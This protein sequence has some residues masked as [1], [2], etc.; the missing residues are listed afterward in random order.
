MPTRARSHILEEQSIRRF[1]DALPPAWVYRCKAPDYGIDGEVEIFNTNG[2]TT[3]LSFNV[4][5]RATDDVARAD[6]VRLEVDE[7]NYYG[8]LDVPT[9][10]VRYSSPDGSLFWQWASHIASQVELA[11]GQQTVTYRFDEGERWTE[12]TAAAIRRTLEVRRRL[13]DYPPSMGVPLRVDLSA[14]PAAERYPIDRTIAQAI[15]DSRGALVRAGSTP[16]DVEAF[17][18]LGPTILSVG[19]DT[20]TGVTFDLQIPTPNDYLSSILYALVRIFRRQ[21]LLRQAEALASL[22]AERGLAHHNQDLAFDAC[23]ALARDLPALV[24]IAIVNGLHDQGPM[25]ALVALTIVK[26]PQD[27]ESRRAAMDAFF[28]ASMA[29]ARE[30]EPASEA[31]AHYSIGNFYRHQHDL[32]RAAHHYNRARHLRPAYLQTGYFLSELAGVLFLAGHYA[33]AQRFYREAVRLT[34]EDPD[35]VFLLGDTLLLS[36]AVR[37]AR[38]CYEVALA[39]CSAPRLL[40]EAN[41]KIMVCDRVIATAGVDTL[42]RR[43]GEASSTLRPDGRD[44]AEHLEHLL[45]DVDAFHPLAHFNLG[46]TRAH[47]GNHV[48]ALHH[49]LACAFIQPQDITAWANSAIC[50]LSL[51]DEALLLR[52]MST[53]IHHM[54]AD[55]YDHFRADVAAQGM[56]SQSL[57]LLDEIA[58]QLLEESERSSSDG[59]TLRLLEGSGYQTMTILGL[60]E[61]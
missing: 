8:S 9:A 54:G 36:G 39:R 58:M 41:L 40:H 3:G 43:R 10:V 34:P 29:A 27:R 4:Q 53:A 16:A 23:I 35:L 20:L 33:F 13:G 50:A 17:A 60:G 52:I 37:E 15:A 18:T 2:S 49:F 21:R 55:A 56:A 47:E 25:H 45:R 30:V 44:S 7:L 59:F 32:A 11:E 38:A 12:A 61:A 26:A 28:G 31:A 6:R 1:G 51:G 19:I 48:A 46:I 14:I 57:A 42:P 24:R 22:L 5:L